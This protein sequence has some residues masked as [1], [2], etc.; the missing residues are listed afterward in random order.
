M[1]NFLSNDL[2]YPG[3]A[4]SEKYMGKSISDKLRIT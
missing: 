4:Y 3:S 1:K 2:L